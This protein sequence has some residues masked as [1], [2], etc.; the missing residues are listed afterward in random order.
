MKNLKFRTTHET[1]P[2]LRRRDNEDAVAIHIDGHL[3]AVA[4]GMGGHFHGRFAS[5][6]ITR[7][8]NAIALAGAFDDDVSEV[9]RAI[10]AANRL[11]Y[12][13]ATMEGA[14]IGSTVAAL[15]AHGS[16]AMCFWVGDSRVYRFRDDRLEQ[17]TRDHTQVRHLL[18]THQIT[19]DEAKHHPMGHVLTRAVGVDAHVRIEVKPVDLAPDDIIL[20]CSDGLT[21]CADE[22]DIAAAL[23][24][25][26][27]LKACAKLVELCLERGAPDNVSIVTVIC[28]EVTAV[29][30][31]TAGA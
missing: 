30:E 8:L 26:G 27:G 23:R 5:D 20:I 13:R 3:W 2:G 12:Q 14:T 28:D 16:Q 22:G 25:Q 19:G 9:Q 10:N 1:H 4:D 11:V 15:Y 6:A 7:N 18:D 21:A 24:E 29:E 31:V 17:L